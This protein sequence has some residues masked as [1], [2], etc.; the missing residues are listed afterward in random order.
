MASNI[1]RLSPLWVAARQVGI[2]VGHESTRQV[3]IKADCPRRIWVGAPDLHILVGRA[4]LVMTQGITMLPRLHFRCVDT[5]LLIH[6]TWYKGRR[7]A[8]LSW[9]RLRTTPQSCTIT[10][11]TRNRMIWISRSD[12]EEI[13]RKRRI[14]G[15]L[16]SVV[17]ARTGLVKDLEIRS[18]SMNGYIVTVRTAFRSWPEDNGDG[19]MWTSSEP[20]QDYGD[21]L[22]PSVYKHT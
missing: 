3:R 9:V 22:P 13:G 11:Q 7:P 12:G 8:L 5:C 21:A 1:G 6:S 4:A 10:I 19:N 20:V 18:R 17:S 2:A 16:Y 14:W 15:Y